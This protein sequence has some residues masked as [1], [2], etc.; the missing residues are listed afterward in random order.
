MESKIKKERAAYFI[1]GIIGY[2]IGSIIYE[3]L[4]KDTGQNV[5]V[6]KFLSGIL[7]SSILFVG[8]RL[9]VNIKHQELRKRANEIEK[10]ERNVLIRE[11]AAYLTLMTILVVL[12]ISIVIFIFKKELALSYFAAFIYIGIYGIFVLSKVYW[13]KKI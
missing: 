9:Y 11:K 10:D 6:F 13:N 4:A 2:F 8:V 12:F 5:A 7:V 3:A 1:A